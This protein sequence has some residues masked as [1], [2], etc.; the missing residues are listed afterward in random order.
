MK[1]KS[2][3]DRLLAKLIILAASKYLISIPYIIEIS[4]CKLIGL[5][6]ISYAGR[7][8]TTVKGVGLFEATTFTG[9]STGINGVSFAGGAQV[10]IAENGSLNDTPK[11]NIVMLKTSDVSSTAIT[12]QGTPLTED[13]EFNS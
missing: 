2:L 7:E 11:N 10:N 1:L 6:S 4:L 9:L 12:L 5:F 3:Q 8:L 13:D